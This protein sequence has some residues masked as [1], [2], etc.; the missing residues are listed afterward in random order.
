VTQH[1]RIDAAVEAPEHRVRAARRVG[2]DTGVL[3]LGDLFDRGL[4]FVFL[5]AATKIYGLE[6]Y[7]AYLIALSVFQVVRTIVSFGLGRSLVRD[8]AAA[9]A[10]EDIGRLKGAIKLGFLIS[11]PLAIVFGSALLFGASEIVAF[12]LPTQTKVVDPMRVFGL[13]TPL[14]SFNF[15][16]LQ[17]LYGLGR[18]RE[19][20]VAN[21]VVEP[22]TRLVALAVLFFAGVSGYYAIPGAYAAALVLSSAFAV[23]VFIKDVWPSMAGVRATMRVKETLAFILPI[24]L[25]DLATRSFRAFN[26]TVFAYFRSTIDV[27]IFNVA[28]KMTGVAFFFSGSLMGAFRPRIAALLAQGRNDLLSEETRVYTRWIFTFALLPYGLMIAFPSDMLGLLGPQFVAA[29]PTL[30]I[31]CVALLI[32]QGAGPL[33]TLMVMSGRSRQSVAFLF[34]A[35]AIYTTLA[36]KV[37]PRYGTIGAAVCGL[38]TILV[39]FPIVTTYVQRSLKIRLYGRRMLKPAGAALVAFAVGLVVSVLLPSVD[40]EHAGHVA[41]IAR[42]LPII[43][44]VVA[45]Y[46]GMLWKL[47]IEPEERAVLE[48]VFAPFTKIRRKLAKIRG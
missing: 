36:L 27:S 43:L 46:A 26:L 38:A 24:T 13:L 15:V 32:G 4:G 33:M 39:F 10:V 16:L 7:G 5:V 17:S 29:A 34:S 30:R 20:V 3:M 22:A 21:N 23:F 35:A 12:F 14:F 42:T 1:A 8:A 44:V 6:I 25:N 41:R 18:I 11:L 19:M 37:V 48:P 40:A 31:L 9:T 2:K 45:T 28:L 47:G